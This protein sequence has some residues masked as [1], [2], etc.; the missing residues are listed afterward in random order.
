MSEKPLTST[1]PFN[2]EELIFYRDLYNAGVHSKHREHA[3]N[4]VM[5]MVDDLIKQLQQIT[6]N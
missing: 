1:K 4:K 3:A 6:F 5:L 2:L